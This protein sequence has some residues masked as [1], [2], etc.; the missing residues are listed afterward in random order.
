MIYAIER[1]GAGLYVL[2]KLGGWAD[3]EELGRCA[4][5]ICAERIKPRQPKPLTTAYPALITPQ[6]HKEDKRR[7]LAI[8]E[9]HQSIVRKRS[10]TVTDKGD[11]SQPPTPAGPSPV[12]DV[13][14]DQ[15][16]IAEQDDITTPVETSLQT[17]KTLTA[18]NPHQTPGDDSVAQ[19][20]AEAIF[21]TIRSQYLEALYHSM[22]GD[23]MCRM[24]HH[25]LTTEI[26][27][28]RVFCQGAPFSCASS[29]P[30]RLRFDP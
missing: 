14:N 3:V 21:Q 25:M 8:E 2:C 26:G 13:P 1:E 11:H 4:T 28:A 7:K 23:V 27:I 9:I 30:S 18:L 29:I 22:V 5:V 17:P 20:N 12:P 6:M 15:S 24:L 10:S 16:V 19:P